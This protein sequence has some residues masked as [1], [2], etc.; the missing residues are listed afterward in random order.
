M[1]SG[2][3]SPWW[4]PPATHNYRSAMPQQPLEASLRCWQQVCLHCGTEQHTSTPELQLHRLPQMLT[5]ER[6]MKH[7][8]GSVIK[9]VCLLVNIEQ[10]PLQFF[11]IAISHA[12]STILSF[13]TYLVFM[14]SSTAKWLQFQNT[15]FIEKLSSNPVSRLTNLY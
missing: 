14:C 6:D 1:R 10:N 12:I 7:S 8:Q 5:K 13:L 9:T 15:N 3:E 11:Q 4:C 2:E